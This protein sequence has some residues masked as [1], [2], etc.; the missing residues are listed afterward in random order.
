MQDKTETFLHTFFTP[1]NCIIDWNLKREHVFTNWTLS[2]KQDNKI[3][4]P[5]VHSFTIL[6]NHL[7]G[8]CLSTLLCA[9]HWDEAAVIQYGDTQG[10]PPQ[11]T[12]NPGS[13]TQHSRRFDRLGQEL[14][15][16]T[17][18]RKIS[19]AGKERR[20][21]RTE[22]EGQWLVRQWSLKH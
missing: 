16:Y 2:A 11:K 5:C 17:E 19:Q 1:P 15:K 10:W 20:C 3:K 7:F 6:V 14:C 22:C 4:C 9:C 13:H 21:V 18:Q 8:K 12:P